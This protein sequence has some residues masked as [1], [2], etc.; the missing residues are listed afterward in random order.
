MDKQGLRGDVVKQNS[1]VKWL[2][3]QFTRSSMSRPPARIGSVS[4][5]AN[6][7]T[8][9]SVAQDLEKPSLPF[10]W[11]ARALDTAS[12]PPFERANHTAVVIANQLYIY[13]GHDCAG[14]T[15]DD[16]AVFDFE[17]NLWKKTSVNR[18]V[19]HKGKKLHLTAE[20]DVLLSP[21]Q[22]ICPPPSSRAFHT[23]VV[24]Q[25]NMVVMGG[26]RSDIE[27]QLYFFAPTVF[28]PVWSLF[29]QENAPNEVKIP[30][31]HHSAVMWGGSTM[32]VFGGKSGLKTL[33]SV[34]MFD[35]KKFKWSVLQTESLPAIHS[36]A[37]FVKDDIMYIVGGCTETGSNGFLAVRLLDGTMASAGSIIPD[38]CMNL[39][40]SLMTV[41]YD[42]GLERIYIFGGF[43][44]SSED[45]ESPCTDHLTIID[46]KTRQVGTL[47]AP[48]ITEGPGPR[49]GHSM[50]M[51]QGRIVVFGGCDR[52][53]L[54]DG[55][56]V[57]C[58]FSNTVWEFVPPPPGTEVGKL[59]EIVGTE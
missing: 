39:N 9:L 58:D 23:A 54:L 48:L 13:G 46:M 5:R 49:C 32:V 36:H 22:E 41:T 25:N 29:I 21:L 20:K 7:M 3:N 56:W 34:I 1:D 19:A 27:G 12:T 47:F 6:I 28:T 24:Y 38:I 2:H 17:H 52:L 53:P 30:R 44:A 10:Y 15:L 33:N 11:H 31:S 42:P 37:C 35:F 43:T 57:F 18:M 51:Y 40:L 50:V 16:L 14:N 4:R 8:S 59:R 26:C 55:E 45:G